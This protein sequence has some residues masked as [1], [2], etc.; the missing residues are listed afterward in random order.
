MPLCERKG[1]PGHAAFGAAAGVLLGRCKLLAGVVP[2]SPVAAPVIAR[3]LAY[4][5]K[6]GASMENARRHSG[7][8]VAAPAAI[9]APGAYAAILS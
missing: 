7:G 8:T 5:C 6:I 2:H 4:R 9:P 3:D 1:R